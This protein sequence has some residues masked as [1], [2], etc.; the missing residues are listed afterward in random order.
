MSP[1]W[2]SLI[3]LL[4]LLAKANQIPVIACTECSEQNCYEKY[5]TYVRYNFDGVTLIKIQR[6]LCNNDRCPRVTFSILPYPMLRYAR[7]SLC[8]LLCIVLLHE[9]GASIQDIAK[10]TG[11]SWAVTQ[12][13]I[14]RGQEIESWMKQTASY[15][16]WKGDI[17][18]LNIDNWHAFIQLFSWHFYPAR[19]G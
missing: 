9:Q 13:W 4:T 19:Y 8:M 10:F 15:S 5:G 12:R 16:P 3:T 6:F 2:L 11:N 18:Q 1:P 17:C 14:R 7:A